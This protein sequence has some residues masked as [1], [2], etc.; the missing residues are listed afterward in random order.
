MTKYTFLLP[1]FKVR[2]F[3][4]AL[5]SIKNQSYKDFRCIVSDDK[6]NDDLKSVY[7]RVCG[8]DVRFIYRRNKVNMGSVSLVAHWNLLV[9]LCDSKYFMMA[10]DDDIYHPTFLEEID[11]L[12]LKYPDVGAVRSRSQYINAKGEIWR[13]DG[14]FP[15]YQDALSFLYNRHSNCFIG[16]ILNYAF[17]RDAMIRENQFLDFPLAWFSDDAAV[18]SMSKYGICC[19]SD[20]LTSMRISDINLSTQATEDLCIKKITAGIMYFK[21][22]TVFVKENCKADNPLEKDMLYNG[23][24]NLKSRVLRDIYPKAKLLGIKKK[25]S[26]SIKLASEI[27]ISRRNNWLRHFV[28]VI[29]GS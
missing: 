19:T 3:E 10:G 21:W 12:L 25:I 13:K 18:M 28:H 24:E 8:G 17:N 26:I 20:I 5:L 29:I 7:D 2:Y 9:K 27:K 11:K 4:E 22:S 15:E 16:G 1:A 14:Q 6:S 23:S